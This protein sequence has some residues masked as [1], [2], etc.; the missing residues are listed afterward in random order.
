M[1]RREVAAGAEQA[2][3]D[4]LQR[5]GLQV[6]DRNWRS[7]RRELDIVVRD[8]EVVA[9]VEVKARG[10][11]PQDPLDAIGWRK[12]RQLRRAAE[13]WVHAHPGI[14]REFRFDAIAVRASEGRA[15]IR[16]VRDV[17]TGDDA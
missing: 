7:G 16:W 14:G 3:A 10:A 11:G 4:F 13:H 17:F 8:G 2:A 9:F 5:R 12:R 6:L 15:R 1:R